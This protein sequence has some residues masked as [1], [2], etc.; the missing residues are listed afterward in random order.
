MSKVYIWPDYGDK[1]DPGDGGVRRVVEAQR[2]Y[3]PEY[4][5][6]VVANPE[7]ADVIAA[8]MTAPSNFFDARLIDKP[9]VAHNHGFYWS[10]YDWGG[11]WAERDNDL[12]MR[13][14]K[15]ADIVTGPS[16]WVA[17]IIR[18]HTLRDVRVIYHGIDGIEK[19]H[20][21]GGYVLW[22]KT[23]VDAVCDPRPVAEVAALLPDVN[24]ASTFMPEGF[25]LPNVEVTGKVPYERA[26]DIAAAAGVYLATTRETFGIGTL[27]ALAA[28]VPVVGY[29]WGGQPEIVEHMRDGYL[30]EPGDVQ[31]LARGIRWALAYRDAISPW[32][33][34]KAQQFLWRDK[35]AAYA[36][37]YDEALIRRTKMG[38]PKVSV[39]VPAYDLD[40]YLPDAL[41]SVQTQTRT[42]WECIVI[43]DASPDN[44]G[45]IADE[46]ARN[47]PRFKVIHNTTNQYLAGAR[48]TGIA[49]ASGDYILP[50]DA[51][52]MLAPNTLEIL[53]AALDSDRSLHIA[54]GG[55]LFVNEDG[56]TPTV[57]PGNAERPGH[58]GW[59]MA[60]DIELLVKGLGQPMPYASMFR[61]DVWA[62]TGGYRTRVR[63][64]EDCDFWMRACSYGFDAR[65]VTTVDTLIY[66]NREDSMSRTSGWADKEN[67]D[68]FPWRH[69]FALLPA[70]GQQGG[71]RI[72]AVDPPLIS[73]VIACGPD[74]AELV[75]D[76]VDSVDAQT[77]RQWECIVVFDGLPEQPMPSWVHSWRTSQQDGK[78]LGVV[79]ARN[80]GAERARGKAL[81]FLDADDFL[82]PDY[83]QTMADVARQSNGAEVLYADFWEDPETPGVFRSYQLPDA[84]CDFVLHKALHAVTAFY[85]R[86]AFEAV[87]GFTENV[88]W[89]DWD[90]QLKLAA[91]GVCA[92]RIASPLWAY[93]KHT[94][95][96][97]EDRYERREDG[98]ADM[99]AR[100]GDYIEGRKT[101][102]GCRTCGGGAATT[103][104]PAPRAGGSLAPP[105][106]MPDAVLLEDTSAISGKKTY[107]GRGTGAVYNF[108]AG[109]PRWVSGRDAQYFMSMPT[110]RRHDEAS[111]QQ[112][113]AATSG[114][115]QITAPGRPPA[116]PTP[117]PI[118]SNDPPAILSFGNGAVTSTPMAD[119]P[120]PPPNFIGNGL[121]DAGPL[122]VAQTFP[123]DVRGA[124]DVTAGGLIPVDVRGEPVAV[125]EAPSR[126]PA[127]IV[128]PEPPKAA[129]IIDIPPPPP[130]PP[131]EDEPD[132]LQR[133]P[134]DDSGEPVE[135]PAT[136]PSATRTAARPAKS[137][138]RPR[139]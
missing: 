117:E 55:V 13:L 9:M 123:I 70:G 113:L 52:D 32:A 89:E 132:D 125:T 38:E 42:D 46:F 77:F 26:K 95:K 86:E 30:A 82:M 74:H 93:R 67:K 98:K 31:D 69:D 49:A 91:A 17:N 25:S 78:P 94:G 34:K 107:R 112:V 87:E 39:I 3:L 139:K 65:M 102:A 103:V 75:R 50:L 97:R 51:D 92:R 11:A 129:P 99:L 124:V 71:V 62:L 29:R 47:D 1:P 35:I 37:L 4:G 64:S 88:P 14:V 2:R 116:A 23:R 136:R 101:L 63:S 24:F 41:R 54:Y 84:E 131:E 28:G 110:F 45:R 44:C 33:L 22:N 137:R 57:Y 111:A 36:N 80:F 126:P 122:V 120:A 60:M 83:L 68:W 73:V 138:G 10:E 19:V 134:I 61:R 16:E 114:E 48:N 115:M 130:A 20:G 66:R 12:V 105:D 27:E 43:D 100:W 109:R 106:G 40:K 18:R 118:G 135:P 79:G 21:N 56:Q 85:P 128:T 15:A 104:F 5:W 76:A 58:S 8:H 59:P 119:L 6:E 121:E 90:L 108:Q 96:R 81:V 127:P 133:V 7:D 72:S 53:T